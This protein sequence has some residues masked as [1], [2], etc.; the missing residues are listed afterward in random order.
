MNNH[1]SEWIDDLLGAVKEDAGSEAIRLIESCG[2][3][4]ASRRNA[5]EGMAKLR[6]AASHCKTR[7]EI[8]D[9]LN[10]Q[11]PILF[12][13]AKDGIIMHLGKD[14]CTCMMAADISQNADM[15]CNCTR[16]HEKATWSVFFD[17]PVD[18]EIVES[19][20]RGGNDCVL[21]IIV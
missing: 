1:F 15:L 13:E 18:V 21:K 5:I 7:T 17:R 10:E 3:G 9:F 2:K 6:K 4:C 16:G 19:I 8:V 20:L 11:L 14:K 12:T